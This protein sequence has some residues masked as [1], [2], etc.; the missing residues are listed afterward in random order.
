MG[1]EEFVKLKMIEESSNGANGASGSIV[2][3]TLID[4]ND[5]KDY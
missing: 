5:E 2:L 4:D 3:G 1:V